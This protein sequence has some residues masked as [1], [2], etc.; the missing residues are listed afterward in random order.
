MEEKENKRSILGVRLT[1]S[2]YQELR[3]VS[4][5]NSRSMSQQARYYIELGMKAEKEVVQRN[6]DGSVK[7][8]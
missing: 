2:D 6:P 3:K 8:D 4:E 7:N 5:E 1:D